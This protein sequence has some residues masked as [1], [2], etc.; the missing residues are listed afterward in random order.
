MSRNASPKDPR[1]VE[2]VY[3]AGIAALEKQKDYGEVLKLYQELLSYW[4]NL[5]RDEKDANRK[6]ELTRKVEHHMKRAE[7]IKKLK[8]AKEAKEG[9]DREGGML[10]TVFGKKKTPAAAPAPS[11]ASDFHNY[12]IPRGIKKTPNKA[13]D[14]VDELINNVMNPPAPRG[15]ARQA[16]GPAQ[17]R[18][19]AQKTPLTTAPSK[20]PESEYEAQ[21]LNEMLDSS[22]GVSWDDIAG[23]TFAKDTI[24]EAVI[25]PNLR[26]DLFVGLRAPPKGVLLYGPPGTGKTLLA[27]AV[28]STS[29]FSF[30]SISASAVTSKYLGEGE[31]LMKA[32]FSVARKH[33]PSVLFFDEIDSLM[34]ARKDNEHEASRRLKTEFMV[35]VD[36]AATCAEDRILISKTSSICSTSITYAQLPLLTYHGTSTRLS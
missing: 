32:V 30:F 17:R 26:P 9:S 23:L 7:D 5:L 19:A 10:G 8:S 36:G 3:L 11:S 4:M 12:H 33:Q 21:I 29:G 25:L 16:N 1:Q 13:T 22:P 18:P 28:A 34:S 35:Q 31:K 14:E 24:K 15:P 6:S 27:K 2:E 20:G